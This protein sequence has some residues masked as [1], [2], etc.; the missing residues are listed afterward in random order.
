MGNRNRDLL[1][2]DIIVDLMEEDLLNLA[3]YVK[4]EAIKKTTDIIEHRLEDYKLIKGD[5]I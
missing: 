3:D 2:H 4:F 1:I 5:I